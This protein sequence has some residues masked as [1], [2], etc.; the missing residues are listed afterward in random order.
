MLP[1]YSIMG[2]LVFLLIFFI[3]CVCAYIK[4]TFRFWA[5]QPVFHV[6]DFYYYLFPPGIINRALPEKN[7]YYNE[8]NIETLNVDDLSDY[9]SKQFVRFLRKHYLQQG[10]NCYTPTKQTILPY[11]IGNHAACFISYYYQDELL[12]H[13]KNSTTSPN[14]KLI[15]VM[16]SRPLHVTLTKGNVQFDL[17]YVDHL[18]VDSM[19]RKQGV[20]PQ[21]IQTHH[22]HQRHRNRNIS[23]SL[24]KR[25][26]VLTGIVP[27]CVYTTYGFDL[28]H[29]MNVEP[30]HPSISLVECGKTN[31]HILLDF[32]K[33]QMTDFDICIQPEVSNLIECIQTKNVFVF[34]VIQENVVTSAYFFRKLS[35]SMRKGCDA[36]CCFASINNAHG[37][38]DTF[39]HAYHVAL[40]KICDKEN[41]LFS[42]VESISNNSILIQHITKKMK[43]SLVSPTA[44]FFYNFAYPTFDPKKCLILY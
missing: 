25:E 36:V 21:I 38:H 19:Y 37:D 4:I 18:C 9:S 11:F 22:Y 39:V 16:S 30:L 31:I 41:F 27:L 5:L 40:S 20:A 1:F 12:H 28:T 42:V 32:I 7:A 3:L 15:G 14:K 6:Y 33:E 26:G 2:C 44:F 35:T 17:Y 24:F 23:I 43:P 10:E 8:T 13:L 29:R 34:M